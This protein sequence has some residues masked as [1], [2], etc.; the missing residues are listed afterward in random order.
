[1]AQQQEQRARREVQRRGAGA[2]G[3]AATGAPGMAAVLVARVA[4]LQRE[5]GLSTLSS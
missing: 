4:A 5:Q 3:R 1:V 2:G